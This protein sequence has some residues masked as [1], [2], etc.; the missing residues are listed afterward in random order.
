MPSALPPPRADEG[1]VAPM[2]EQ[3]EDFIAMAP[4]ALRPAAGAWGRQGSTL[5]RLEAVGL[6]VLEM[7]L[8]AAWRRRSG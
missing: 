4:A 6:D 7:A 2:P 1:M 5:V 3:Q 8:A